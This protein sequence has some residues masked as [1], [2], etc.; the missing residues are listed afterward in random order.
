MIATAGV[1]SPRHF[2]LHNMGNDVDA[3]GVNTRCDRSTICHLM[4][5]EFPTTDP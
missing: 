4:L 2:E 3:S 1:P 5:L